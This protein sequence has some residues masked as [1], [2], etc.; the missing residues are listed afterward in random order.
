MLSVDSLRSYQ[1]VADITAIYPKRLDKDVLKN[2]GGIIYTIFGLVGECGEFMELYE[3]IKYPNAVP[4]EQVVKEA[5]DVCW[6]IVEVLKELEIPVDV[7]SSIMETDVCESIL[8]L[9][10][11]C[12]ELTKKKIRDS[13]PSGVYITGIIQCLRCILHNLE[14]ILLGSGISLQE[15]FDTNNKKLL[16]RM[17]RGKLK[18]EGD[19][20]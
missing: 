20:R 6:Y 10:C 2:T 1:E 12:A 5:G 16:S 14:K 11:R 7:L 13:G 4:R 18:G 8:T 3:G 19:D 17:E 9:A 15:V